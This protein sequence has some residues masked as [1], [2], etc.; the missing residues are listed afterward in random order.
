MAAFCTAVRIGFICFLG[1]AKRIPTKF[2]LP[3]HLIHTSFI[4]LCYPIIVVTDKMRRESGEQGCSCARSTADSGTKRPAVV[5]AAIM[6]GPDAF[7]APF[8]SRRD[9][10]VLQGLPLG[11]LPMEAPVFYSKLCILYPFS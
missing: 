5:W 6:C 9:E 10:M 8:A 3:S 7:R 4:P 1:N 11:K 2:T